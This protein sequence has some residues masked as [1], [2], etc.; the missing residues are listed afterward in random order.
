MLLHTNTAQRLIG[1]LAALALLLVA[2]TGCFTKHLYDF[3]PNFSVNLM[4]PD[5]DWPDMDKMRPAEIEVF[6]KYGEPDFFR[7]WYNRRGEIMNRWEAGPRI[8]TKTVTD[9]RMS[10]IYEDRSVEIQFKS[11]TQFVEV[12]LS[13]KLKVLC[14]RGD[15]SEIAALTNPKDPAREAWTYFDVGEKYFFTEEGRF[16]RPKQ[17]LKGISRGI[18]RM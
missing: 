13:D 7:P 17:V 12:P 11:P 8:R 10:W 3:D 9:L 16:A 14:E 4:T 18:Q 2:A 1:R 6:E 5:E 15:P